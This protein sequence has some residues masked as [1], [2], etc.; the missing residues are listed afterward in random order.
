VL[1]DDAPKTSVRGHRNRRKYRASETGTQVHAC[2]SLR[3]SQTQGE[4]PPCLGPSTQDRAACETRRKYRAWA[5]HAR[6]G[7]DATENG[8]KY[9]T[10]LRG[11]STQDHMLRSLRA[12]Q[13]IGK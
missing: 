2:G 7:D 1:G 8:E 6:P 13:A 5:E 10:V 4:I 12:G 11:P 3:A 9:T